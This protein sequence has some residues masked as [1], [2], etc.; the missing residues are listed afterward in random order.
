MLL[1]LKMEE[2]AISP[3]LQAAF[4]NWESQGNILS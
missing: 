2:G 3:T 4:R 1:V